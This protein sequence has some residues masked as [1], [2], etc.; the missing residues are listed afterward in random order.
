M[1]Y[2]LK[3]HP[4]AVKAFFRH[5]LVLT[6]ALRPEALAGGDWKGFLSERIQDFHTAQGWYRSEAGLAHFAQRYR[7][8]SDGVGRQLPD[9]L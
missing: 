5:S 7:Q 6:Y 9:A 3:R 8:P 1:L 4:I 2:L